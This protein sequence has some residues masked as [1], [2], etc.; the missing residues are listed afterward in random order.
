M[1]QGRRQRPMN[2]LTMAQNTWF[3]ESPISTQVSLY[4]NGEIHIHGMKSS[5][6]HGIVPVGERVSP[7]RM[8]EITEVKFK[9]E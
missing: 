1:E 5:W 8:P 3:F 9:N 6:M 7:C 2:E 4:E